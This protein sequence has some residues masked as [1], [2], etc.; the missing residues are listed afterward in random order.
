MADR[1]GG[2][3]FSG[4][5]TAGF[6]MAGA[7]AR[8]ILAR[9]N[10][11][12]VAHIVSI[13]AVKT[14]QLDP[15]EALSK[16]PLSPIRCADPA[17]ES[18]FREVLIE[19]GSKRDSLGGIVELIVAG[20]PA[21]WGEPVFDT[22]EGEMAKA[23]FAIPAVKGVEFGA[24]F[25][26]A[27]LTGS[28][29]NDPFILTEGKIVTSTNNAGGILGGI[30]NGMPITA[31]VAFKPTPSIGQKQDTIDLHRMEPATIEIKGR[32]DTCVVPR[33]VVVVEAMAAIVLCDL[34]LRAGGIKRIMA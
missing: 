14:P 19:A 7:V 23:L 12:I 11:K 5:I 25:R 33:A 28:Q 24:G 30:S 31:R 26:A 1:R 15:A 27:S 17:T 29:N 4:R 6:V 18:L 2:G 10:I 34:G 8:Q 21:G 3:R 20:V 32:H 13:G 22:L 16:A 9:H